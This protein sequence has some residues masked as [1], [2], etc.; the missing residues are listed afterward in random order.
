MATLKTAGPLPTGG[1]LAADELQRRL[2]L[3]VTDPQSLKVLPL[4]VKAVQGASIDVRLGQWFKV[5]RRPKLAALPLNTAREQ[6][7]ATETAHETMFLPLTEDLVIHPG[8]FV[9]GITLEFVGLPNDLMASVEGKSRPGRVGLLV[10][11]ATTVGPGFH[12]SIVLELVNAGQVPLLIRPG[13]GIA[14]LV[15]HTLVGTAPQYEGSSDCQ[16]RP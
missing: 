3:G 13:T 5:A 6:Q 9:L 11:T 4:D 10:A 2:A 14:Q 7:L 12:G 8:D 1:A 15:F 16:I